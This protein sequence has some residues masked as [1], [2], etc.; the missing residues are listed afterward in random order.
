MGLDMK[1]KK[2]LTEETAKRYCSANKKQKSKIID[3]FTATTGYNRK[4][5]IHI[6]KNTARIKITHFNNVE[7]KTVHIITKQ[8]KKRV[9]VKY[10][11][12]KV[13]DEVIH[14]WIFS[15][16][17]CSKRLVTFIRDNIDY[18]A[19]K[20]GYSDL[21]KLKLSKI[22][23]ATIGRMLKTE[24]PK[25]SIRG[26]STTRPAKNLNKLIPIRVYFEWNSLE[27]GF[28]EADTVANCGMSTEGQY[29]STLT[30]TDIYSGWTE[31]RAL[32]NKAQR[33]VKEAVEDIYI[34]LPFQMKGIDSDNGTELKNMQLLGWC[35]KNHV[36]FTRSRP[37]KKNDNCYVEQ[38][39]D[40]V[41]RRIVGYY[42]FEGEEARAVMAE[43]YETYNLLVNYFFPSMKILKKERVDSKITKKYDEAKTPFTRLMECE[44]LPEETKLKLRQRKYSLDLETLL[45]KTQELQAT[46]IALSIPWSK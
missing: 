18:C 27:P 45:N 12:D 26:I 17:L 16:F 3:E 13:K 8:R 25:Y 9:Y 20:F 35:Q 6:L 5:A 7:K 10:Y 41:V 23:S 21:L 33:W 28:F 19:S 36:E 44:T 4:Y 14:L 40:S 42:R 2:K 22:S 38:K 29:I 32:L 37:Y 46:L 34:K 43:L 11:D 31:N 30:L 1:T 15:M 39:N 24:I